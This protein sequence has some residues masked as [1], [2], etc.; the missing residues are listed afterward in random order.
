MKNVESIKKTTGVLSPKHTGMYG[1][2]LA[3]IMLK[4]N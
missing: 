3:L 4:S 2:M 1:E